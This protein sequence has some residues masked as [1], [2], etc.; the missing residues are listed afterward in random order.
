[1]LRVGLTG[2]L[3][4]GKST[5]ARLLAACGALVLSS[6]EMGRAMMQPGEAVFNAIVEHFGPE[7]L[8]PDG[9][10]DRQAL[11]ALAFDPDRPRVEELNAI[12]H[13]AVIAEQERRLATI[14]RS[15]PQAIVVIESALLF[16]T[17]FA[18]GDQPWRQRFD[19]IVVVT[20]PDALKLERFIARAS[21]GAPLTPE[22]R[23]HLLADGG[24]RLGAQRIP[25]A[26]LAG[27]LVLENTGN[28]ASLEEHTEELWVELCRLGGRA[29]SGESDQ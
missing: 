29:V 24:A 7:I 23:A 8:R 6:D 17:K 22:Q 2:E 4:S 21:A 5:V 27:C 18:G 19:Q 12:V 14:A 13:P 28:L 25:A 10:L 26:V 16:T 1:M 15:D 11:A 3:G 20:A 9:G